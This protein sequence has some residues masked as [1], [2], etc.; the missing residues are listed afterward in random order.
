MCKYLLLF[1]IS[2]SFYN[3]TTAQK[4]HQPDT[5]LDIALGSAA[6][7]TF[8]LGFYFMGKTKPLTEA[9][10]KQLDPLHVNPFDRPATK[11]WNMKAHHISDIT[12]Q[13]AFFGQ[14]LLLFDKNS[15]DE[16]ATIGLMMGE[17]ALL[18]NGITNI[19]KG[20]IRRCRPF[21]YNDLAPL[22]KKTTKNGRFSFFSG[23]A[24]NSATYAFLT[25]KVYSDNN[26]GS[27]WNPYIW[28]AAA[29][30]PALTALLRVKAGRHFPG[31]V[32]V[33][34]AVGAAVGFLVPQLHKL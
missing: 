7:A 29:T 32:M 4:S 8:G 27:K 26:P 22:Q 31:D 30:L 13:T 12:L 9:E 34:Y 24:S 28:T 18:N 11:N 1:L 21:T 3:K 2:I 6:G 16:A 20:T 19:F 5:R 25:A 14:F 15:R 17:A 10:I 33:G 23:H